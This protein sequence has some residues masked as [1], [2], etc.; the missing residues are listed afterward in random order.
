MTSG[1][2]SFGLPYLSFSHVALYNL[3]KGNLYYHASIYEF[4]LF[5]DLPCLELVSNIILLTASFKTQS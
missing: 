5:V 2:G 1:S 3:G 4:D